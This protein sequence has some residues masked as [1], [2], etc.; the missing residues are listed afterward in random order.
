LEEGTQTWDLWQ[1]S[2]DYI[3][4]YLKF[5]FFNYE[6]PEEIYEGGRPRV[7]EMGPYVYK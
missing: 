3:N 2:P 5:T 6:N 4:I 7:K 1:E